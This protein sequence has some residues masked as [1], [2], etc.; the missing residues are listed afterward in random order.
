MVHGSAHACI[1]GDDTPKVYDVTD[2]DDVAAPTTAPVI[3]GEYVPRY[4]S[5]EDL[6]CGLEDECPRKL[7]HGVRI[8]VD[9]PS[10]DDRTVAADMAYRIEVVKGP[11]FVGTDLP[12]VAR[13]YDHSTGNG[14]F[15]FR[16]DR[17]DFRVRVRVVPVDA[18]GNEGP[19]SNEVTITSDA[20]GCSVASRRDSRRW[21]LL[22]VAAMIVWKPLARRRRRRPQA[23]QRSTRSTSRSTSWASGTALE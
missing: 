22:F 5:E 12:Q 4:D 23:F 14:E 1:V 7:D 20:E 19:P 3:S 18:G 9:A 16:T 21:A 13:P 17:E 8:V 11:D 10:E 2:P 15:V 6:G